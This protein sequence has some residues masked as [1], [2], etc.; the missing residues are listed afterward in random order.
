M[1]L[2]D[3]PMAIFNSM[4]TVQFSLELIVKFNKIQIPERTPEK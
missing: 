2:A 3:R 4:Y 1:A